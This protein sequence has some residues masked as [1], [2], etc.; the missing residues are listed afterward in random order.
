MLGQSVRCP[1]ALHYIWGSSAMLCMSDPWSWDFTRWF[2]LES[3]PV[4]IK[5]ELLCLLEHIVLHL[6]RLAQCA[7][8]KGCG[9]QRAG[10]RFLRAGRSNVTVLCNAHFVTGSS[11]ICLYN[12]KN[13]MQVCHTLIY[14]W[15]LLWMWMLKR[16]LLFQLCTLQC[17][18]V[19]AHVTVSA[20]SRPA[21]PAAAAIQ[22]SKESS[23]ELRFC[24]GGSLVLE[25]WREGSK[26]WLE[27]WRERRCGGREP[28]LAPCHRGSLLWQGCSASGFLRGKFKNI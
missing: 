27:P 15:C 22:S 24:P 5:P 13:T 19:G 14:S 8:W 7:A 26:V 1:H 6:K 4:D 23:R 2:D 25:I 18:N 12:L 20:T 9:E 17:Y 10:E 28:P 16:K 11:T 21:R 3:L